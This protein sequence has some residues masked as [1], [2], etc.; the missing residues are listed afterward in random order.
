MTL[1]LGA[2]AGR[3]RF[4]VRVVP[5]ASRAVVGGVREGELLVRVTAAPVEGAANSAVVAA[6]AKTLGIAPRDVRLEAGA[7]GRSKVVS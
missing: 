1:A 4:R 3:V 2:A 7:R 6:L 5:R